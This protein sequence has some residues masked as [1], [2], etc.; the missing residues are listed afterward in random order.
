MHSG[1]APGPWYC[2]KPLS[3]IGGLE[4]ILIGLG[5]LTAYLLGTPFGDWP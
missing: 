2:P 1:K 4:L 3:G 5:V